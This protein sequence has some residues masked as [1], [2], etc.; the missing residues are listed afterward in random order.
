MNHGYILGLVLR[1][2]RPL[3]GAL[4]GL[5]WAMSGDEIQLPVFSPRANVS[6]D[7]A[8]TSGVRGLRAGSPVQSPNIWTETNAQGFFNLS[9]LWRGQ[10]IAIAMYYPYCQIFVQVYD[11]VTRTMHL[12]PRRRRVALIPFTRLTIDQRLA[13]L[14]NRAGV[15]SHIES[16]RRLIAQRIALLSTE[17]KILLGVIRIGL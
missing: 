10:D 2:G 16:L 11:P 3:R 14:A 9:F 15:G 5:E 17:S 1:S 7:S 12:H 13:Q 4:I 8:A 6:S